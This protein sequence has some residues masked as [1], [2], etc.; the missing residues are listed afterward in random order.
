MVTLTW[1]SIQVNLH[2]V[3]RVTMVDTPIIDTTMT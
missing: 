1:V 3:M 2:V